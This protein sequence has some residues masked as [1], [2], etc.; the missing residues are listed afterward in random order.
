MGDFEA[1][2]DA[3]EKHLKFLQL[4]SELQN[5]GFS[6]NNWLAWHVFVVCSDA[7]HHVD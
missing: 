5:H 7:V 4:M 2:W 6:G 3:V 1:S